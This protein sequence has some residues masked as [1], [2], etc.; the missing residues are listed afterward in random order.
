MERYLKD[1]PK[2]HTY[3]NLS[4]ADMDDTPW[5][6]FATP[7]RILEQ[8]NYHHHHH[9]HRH[10]SSHHHHSH[11]NLHQ[12]HHHHHNNH[13]HHSHSSPSSEHH[14]LDALSTSSMSSACSAGSWDSQL[15]CCAIVVKKEKLDADDECSADDLHL[16]HHDDDEDLNSDGYEEKMDLGEY[17]HITIKTETKALER[18]LATAR[19]SEVA[20]D[21]ND[22]MLPTLTPPSSPESIRIGACLDAADL[23]TLALDHRHS[24]LHKSH[25][26][27]ASASSLSAHSPILSTIGGAHGPRSAIVRLTTASA[28]GD[29]VTTRYIQISEGM[30]AP[31]SPPGSQSPINDDE[32][33][34]LGE[35]RIAGRCSAYS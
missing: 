19:S 26:Q 34:T 22:L 35:W 13:H 14:N 3:K 5:D 1:E 33:G 11:H 25:R 29:S 18:L 21:P 8:L 9:H 24:L 2:L 15:S 17:N 28:D 4:A 7:A 10:H 27:S 16:H 30:L 6:L 20:D 12:H 31:A 32:S 23:T